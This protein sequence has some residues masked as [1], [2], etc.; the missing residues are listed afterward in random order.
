MLLINNLIVKLVSILG[1]Y[2]GGFRLSNVYHIWI[3]QG[4][5]SGEGDGV[6][7]LSISSCSQ[8]RGSDAAGAITDQNKEVV[9]WPT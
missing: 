3:L 8:G 9:T 4:D 7:V 2:R 5:R 6:S 1:G